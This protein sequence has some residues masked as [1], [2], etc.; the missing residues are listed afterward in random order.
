MRR[1]DIAAVEVRLPMLAPRRGRAFVP[2]EL[3]DAASNGEVRVEPLVVRAAVGDCLELTLEN[4]L[5]Q[6]SDAVSIHADGLA[7]DPLDSGLEVGE[8]PAHLVPV[9]ERDTYKFYVHPEYGT[10]VALLRDGG[11]LAE[12]AGTGLYGAVAIAPTGATFDHALG[13]KAA[14]TTA[15]GEQWRDAV[16]FMQ[17][18]DEGIG[19]H[20]MPYTTAIR[21]AAGLNYGLGPTAPKLDAYAGE[22]LRIHV[23]APWSEQVQVFALEGHRWPIEPRMS[24]STLVG[25]TAIGGLESLTLVPVG[26]AGGEAHL[27][28]TYTFGNHREA[29]REA[30]IE[31]ALVVH[32]ACR[33]RVAELPPLVAVAAACGGGGGGAPFLPV[34]AA[35]VAILAATAAFVVV[36][37][38]QRVEI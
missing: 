26:G 10:G 11:D 16:V 21:G 35:A 14:V 9:G 18:S 37:R 32:D 5:P 27:P 17:D 19:T 29:Y 22:P 36:R 6:G 34:G 12:S 15:D 7:Y 1:Y 2:L 28:G 31:G 20:R 25:S 23:V 8:N 33:E 24:G 3:A 30:G 4:R 13:W 38:R